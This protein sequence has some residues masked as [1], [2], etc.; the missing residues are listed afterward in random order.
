[1]VCA[2]ASPTTSPEVHTQGNVDIL[3]VDDQPRDSDVNDKGEAGS[4]ASDTRGDPVSE[5]RPALCT[6]GMPVARGL[7][8]AT[9]TEV[10]GMATTGSDRQHL[11]AHM[12]SGDQAN[13]YELSDTGDIIR[14]VNLQGLEPVDWEDL[15]SGPCADRE[16][17]NACLYIGDI[18]DN[19]AARPQ[20]SLH[21]VRAPAADVKQ[22]AEA[23]IETVSLIYP[24][25]PR[26]C[27]ALVVDDSATVYLLTKLWGSFAFEVYAVPFKVG[28]GEATLEKIAL[29]DISDVDQDVL[30]LVTAADFDPETGRL[31]VRTYSSILM[32]ALGSSGAFSQLASRPMEVIPSQNEPQGEAICF[33]DGG[34]WHGSEGSEAPLWWVPCQ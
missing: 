27:E 34:L 4:F 29:V 31:A 8:D 33:G 1:M 24:D 6:F 26:D 32:Y 23:D 11:W 21:R 18:G 30:G 16:E 10:S 7:L 25:G 20:I 28:G 22:V 5:A 15:A 12:D 9:L 3:N 17:P 19:L 13:L 2:C 14:T